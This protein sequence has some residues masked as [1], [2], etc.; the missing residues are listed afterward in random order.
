MPVDSFRGHSGVV[1]WVDFVRFR[2]SPGR[3]ESLLSARSGAIEAFRRRRGL[4]AAYLVKLEQGV[5]L[6]GFVWEGDEAANDS[7]PTG[8]DLPEVVG[9]MDHMTEVLGEERGILVEGDIQ[10]G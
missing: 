4:R 9:Y 7:F 10:G 8:A 1:S 2:V 5:W 6:D 3:A